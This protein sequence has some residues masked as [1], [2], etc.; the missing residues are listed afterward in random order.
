MTGNGRVWDFEGLTL[1]TSIVPSATELGTGEQ[2]EVAGAVTDA[3]GRVTG[4][5]LVLQSRVPGAVDWTDVSP[6][7]YSAPDGSSRATVTVEKTRSSAGCGPRASTP[8]A[9]ASEPVLVTVTPA[10]ALTPAAE[11]QETAAPTG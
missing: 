8:T 6:L 5:P 3:T 9:G 4:D 7:T 10:S 11:P 2:V 1:A